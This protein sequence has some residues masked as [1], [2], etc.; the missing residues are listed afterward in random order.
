MKSLVD[1]PLL[2]IKRN[3]GGAGVMVGQRHRQE[4]N[5]SVSLS[6]QKQHSSEGERRLTL[7]SY[8]KN[9]V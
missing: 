1:D 6:R 9:L 7:V 2:A 4:R 8:I 3:S 5:M